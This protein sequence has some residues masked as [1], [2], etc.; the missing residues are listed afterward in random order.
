MLQT[1]R[2]ELVDF[3]IEKFMSMDRE[4]PSYAVYKS[5]IIEEAKENIWFYFRELLVVPDNESVTGYSHFKLTPESMMMIYLYNNKKSFINRNSNDELCLH[6]LW[7][8]HRSLYCS[9]IV[10]MNSSGDIG[11][12][13]DSIKK[14]IAH[15]EC[16]VPYGSTQAI[17]DNST[18]SVGCGMDFIAN[19][20]I[21]QAT[22]ILNAAIDSIY[23]NCI[24]RNAW[25]ENNPV[26]FILEHNMP[27][28]SYSYIL[29]ATQN[30][31]RMYFNGMNNSLKTGS[32]ILYNMLS[33]QYEVASLS[34]Y[35][36]NVNVLDELYL[37]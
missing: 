33:Y 4:D 37:I 29:N 2:K 20:G 12:I 31:Y 14:H 15:M 1:I 27:A 17:S 5:T 8:L 28:L 13:S 30:K 26:L 36:K 7:N 32:I 23:E 24:K 19:Y 16:Q 9:D 11:D 18:H 21:T 34:L 3:S 35:D 22:K 25:T 6:F 10:L